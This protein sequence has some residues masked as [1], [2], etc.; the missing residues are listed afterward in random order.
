MERLRR[1]CQARKH[2]K[3]LQTRL[4]TAPRPDVHTTC[5]RGS[6]TIVC[7]FVVVRL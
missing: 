5:V 4:P 3:L 6:A 2:F 1:Q 7:L